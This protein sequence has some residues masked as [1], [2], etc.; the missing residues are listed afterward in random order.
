MHFTSLVCY[1]MATKISGEGSSISKRR[2]TR[3]GKR[4]RN[5]EEKRK[6]IDEY[7]KQRKHRVAPSNTT[8]FL[9][10]DRETVEPILYLSPPSSVSSHSSPEADGNVELQFDL[11]IDED[12]DHFDEQFFLKDF[13]ATYR[14]LYRENLYS[15][16]K[17]ELLEKV[18]NL[19][20]QRDLLEKERLCRCTGVEG[21]SGSP[22]KLPSDPLRREFQQLQEQNDL[23]REEN[24]VLRKA[25]EKDLAVLSD[26]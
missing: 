14:Q 7:M 20:S 13:E 12:A 5:L 9:M 21:N 6:F 17:P 19:E 1:K 10:E 11:R 16:S 22:N 3:R 25:K 24:E 23:L 8:Q 15:F 26:S 4:W 18:K 2:K